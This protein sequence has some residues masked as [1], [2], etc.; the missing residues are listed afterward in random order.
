MSDDTASNASQIESELNE[1][2]SEFVEGF[3]AAAD[4]MI[5]GDQTDY[6]HFWARI[7]ELNADFKSLR[8]RHEDREALWHRM[9]EI[10]D[11]VKEQQ[12]SQR[13]RKEQLLNE[14][15]DRVWNAVNHLK[16]AHDLDYVGN[17][18]RGADLKEF[19]ADAK[20]VSETFRETKPMRRS[21]REE[22]WDDFQRI[23][24][25]VREMQEQKH[26]EW[27]E[28]NR[29]HLD[30]WHAQ[31]DKGEDMIEKLKGQIDHCEDLK[32]D[33]RSDDFADQVQGWI[34][35]KERIIDDIESRNAELWEKI[36]DVEA[37]LRN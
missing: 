31:I 29:E 28:R 34:E 6:S 32:A 11:A 17:F 24:E 21:D 5:W 15:R 8:L 35:E 26:E 18:L 36:R 25:W 16:H 13:E 14:N 12:H 22:L 2:Q 30:R 1:L 10:C 20:E 19:W 33:A 27:V 7:R 3:F 4:H 9:G 37:R 23:C